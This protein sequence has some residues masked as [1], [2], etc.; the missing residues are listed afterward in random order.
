M[1]VYADW[2]G[3][4][5]DTL[6]NL[7]ACPREVPGGYICRACELSD[8]GA[9]EIFSSEEAL[10]RDHLFEPFLQRVNEKLAPAEFLSLYGTP[11]H[12]TWAKLETGNGFYWDEPMHRIP[13]RI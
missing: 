6:I 11:G 2:K 7:I 12:M 3:E 10:W 8:S 1:N 9:R 5:W 4:N 13:L